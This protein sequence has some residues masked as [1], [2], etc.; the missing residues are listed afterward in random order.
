M[1]FVTQVVFLDEIF[2]FLFRL[3]MKFSCMMELN[4]YPLDVQVCTMEIA[5]CKSLTFSF[6]LHS[7]VICLFLSFLSFFLCFSLQSFCLSFFLSFLLSQIKG[8]CCFSKKFIRLKM[9]N[10][11]LYFVTIN[12]NNDA[13]LC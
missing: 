3:K 2:F 4:K 13:L 9:S 10:L 7:S 11:S 8:V 5:S 1:Y 12:N 6:F